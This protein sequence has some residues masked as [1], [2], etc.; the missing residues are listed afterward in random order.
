MVG[1]AERSRPAGGNLLTGTAQ[2]GSGLVRTD[3]LPRPRYRIPPVRAF[4][5]KNPR[6]EKKRIQDWSAARPPNRRAFRPIAQENSPGER[7][8]RG[9]RLGFR[10]FSLV[11]KDAF[12]Q[13]NSVDADSRLM[14]REITE[15]GCR[16]IERPEM[17]SAGPATPAQCLARDL[18][19]M[20][21]TASWGHLPGQACLSLLGRWP[22][23]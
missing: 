13:P 7:T 2:P 8:N 21:W 15:K 23:R 16:M 14:N 3:S 4:P 22:A 6:I 10:E 20:T 12:T 11:N 17:K 1:G 9:C 18:N 19:I 5:F